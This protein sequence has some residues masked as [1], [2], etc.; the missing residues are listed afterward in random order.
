MRDLR[1]LVCMPME[2]REKRE[3]ERE[4]GEREEKKKGTKDEKEDRRREREREI[5]EEDDQKNYIFHVHLFSQFRLQL[6]VWLTSLPCLLTLAL[7]LKEEREKR[8]RGR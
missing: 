5:L 3:R 4:G 6:V 7:C 8:E 1:F 2:K